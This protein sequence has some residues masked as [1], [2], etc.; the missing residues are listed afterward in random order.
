VC[1]ERKR[2][3]AEIPRGERIPDE[4]EGVKTDVVQQAPPVIQ[5]GWTSID[6]VLEMPCA[7]SPRWASVA[8]FV[9]PA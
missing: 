8:P 5:P 9:R 7:R 6:L 4:I 2:P 1:V 3:L